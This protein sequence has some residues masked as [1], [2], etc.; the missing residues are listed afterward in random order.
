MIKPA[1]F[2][3]ALCLAPFVCLAEESPASPANPPTPASAPESAPA[4]QAAL[5]KPAPKALSEGE[6]ALLRHDGLYLIEHQVMPSLWLG[7]RHEM[8]DAD[9]HKRGV[10]VLRWLINL[11]NEDVGTTIVEMEGIAVEEID[12]G[13]DWKG[14]L[15]TFPEPK[16]TPESKY[17]LLLTNGEESRF[18]AWEFDNLMEKTT[19]YLC[20]WTNGGNDHLNYGDHNDGSRENFIALTKKTL[21][22][23]EEVKAGISR[24]GDK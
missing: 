13:N 4:E 12:L 5:E 14:W 2:A 11:V 3:L 9:L 8:F 17:S 23:K 21:A 15:F 18:F 24:N 6:K 22:G 1:A 19:W 7:E 20:E 16:V 10:E